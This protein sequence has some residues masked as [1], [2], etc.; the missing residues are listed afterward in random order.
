M[1]HGPRQS[2][3]NN[4]GAS[5]HRLRR[6][7]YTTLDDDATREAALNDPMTFLA[8]HEGMLTVDE[9]QLSGN[10]VVRTIKRLVDADTTPGRF[11]LTGSTNSLTVP[12]IRE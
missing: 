3:E 4:P 8:E 12:N 6:G 5:R 2:G 11:V 10:R 1:V 9:I 7:T